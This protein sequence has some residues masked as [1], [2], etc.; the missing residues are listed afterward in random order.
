MQFTTTTAPHVRITPRIRSGN[1]KS[2]I[3]SRRGDLGVTSLALTLPRDNWNRKSFVPGRSSP[4]IAECHC[5]KGRRRAV[6]H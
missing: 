6:R 5:R 3:F 2:R 1:V 4:A